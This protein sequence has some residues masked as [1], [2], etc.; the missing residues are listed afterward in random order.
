MQRGSKVTSVRVGDP[1][2]WC[3]PIKIEG[4][5]GRVKERWPDITH[6]AWKEP[7]TSPY[8]ERVE[9][10]LPSFE[11]DGAWPWNEAFFPKPSAITSQDGQ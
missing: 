4:I 11:V 9:Q 6:F 8:R 3:H 1:M 7:I 10:G 2:G 5:F